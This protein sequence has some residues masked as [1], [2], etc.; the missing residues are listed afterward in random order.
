[1]DETSKMCTSETDKLRLFSLAFEMSIDGIIIGDN[2]GY[3]TYA[4]Q[5]VTKM[6]G[7]NNT[8]D[9]IG[10][11][12]LELVAECDKL[13]AVQYSIDFQKNGQSW[14]GRFI[15]QIKDGSLLPVEITVAPIKDQ[16]G[17]RLGFINIV[18]DISEAVANE[19]KLNDAYKKL[20]L[21]NEKLLVVGGL[22]RHDIANK[23]TVLN[24]SA[25]L[26]KKHNKTDNLIQV[27]ETVSGQIKRILTMSRDYERLGAEQLGF[28]N[29]EESFREALLLF[30]N[31]NGI[32]VINDSFGLEVLADSLLR[33]LFYNLIDNT[34]KYGEKTTQISLS[35]VEKEDSVKLFYEDNGTGIPEKI[36]EK[37]FAKGFGKGTGLG[38]Y[39]VKKITEVYGWQIIETGVEGKGVVF[40]ITIPAKNLNSGAENFKIK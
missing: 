39:L 21:A 14:S 34:L 26:A 38:L 1:M 17:D 33:E 35:Y 8:N 15:S 30:A 28:K 3:I 10:K 11:Y 7:S 16:N 19:K 31:L 25:F 23:L 4:N 37:V 29:V 22:V 40:E 6:Y 24:C 36:K 32:R 2:N 5:A 18:R 13:R 20:E 9:L 12:V 27:A